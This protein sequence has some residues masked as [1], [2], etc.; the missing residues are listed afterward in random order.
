ML[1]IAM[2]KCASTAV[3]ETLARAH[4]LKCDMHRRF[5]T[6]VSTEFPG[7]QDY[8]GQTW[9]LDKV[10]A[11]SI[12]SDDVLYKL[13]I[14]PSVNN[15]RLLKESKKVILVRSVDGIVGAH[16]RGY[17]TKIHVLETDAFTGCITEKDWIKQ[18]KVIGL[19]QNLVRFRKFWADHDGDKLV[20]SYEEMIENPEKH[21]A[22]IEDYFG[23][24]RSGTTELL[25]R[26]YT[27]LG[28]QSL[29][30]HNETRRLWNE[31]A[32]QRDKT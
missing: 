31:V 3:T 11:H 20:V 27:R 26:K 15:R 28:E 13:H 19:Y 18:S 2:P 17:E 23:L 1:L 30:Y 32:A 6:E 8:Y 22:R 14:L 29:A 7:I 9:E 10:S 5:G 21:I 12:V 4:G 16:R 25:K 24:K